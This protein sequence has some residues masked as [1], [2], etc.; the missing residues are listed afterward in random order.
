LFLV[1][2]DETSVFFPPL[3]EDFLG[4]GDSLGTMI[5]NCVTAP[6]VGAMVFLTY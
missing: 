6:D 1:G 2:N 5:E 3:F 4:W